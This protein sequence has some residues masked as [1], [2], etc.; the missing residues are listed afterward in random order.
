MLACLAACAAD[1]GKSGA[2]TRSSAS[3]ASTNLAG[4]GASLPALG[5][6]QSGA[7]AQSPFAIG[8]NA[9]SGAAI[10]P[11]PPNTAP[12]PAAGCE[13]NALDQKGCACS[14]VGAQR[15][16]YSAAPETRNVGACKD[17]TQVCTAVSGVE[18]GAQWGACTEQVVPTECTAQLD[19]RCV[20]K[21]GCA[22]EQCADKLGCQK[23]A[24]MPDAGNPKCHT[25]MGF[26]QGFGFFPDG[27]MWCEK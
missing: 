26:G 22:D 25:V 15:V 17:G 9:G 13:P 4:S 27:G 5:T 23:D 10:L 20:G 14:S 19:A 12:P 24:G 6:A 2:A 7:A 11:P 21:V 18:F 8:A 16:C 1:G 3:S